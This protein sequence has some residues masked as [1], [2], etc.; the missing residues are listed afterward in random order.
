MEAIRITINEFLNCG[1]V[2]AEPGQ[3][4]EILRQ[5]D[6]SAD[7]IAEYDPN[8]L[9]IGFKIF[10]N[11]DE[12]EFVTAALDK[13]IFTLYFFPRF[14]LNFKILFKAF[15]T[16]NINTVHN[17]I[18]SFNQKRIDIDQNETTANI[19]NIWRI[20]ERYVRNK[21]IHQIGIS[22]IEENVFRVLYDWANVKPSIIQINLATCCVVPPSL[23]LFCKENEIQLLTHSDPNG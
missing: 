7:K 4:L 16:L 18:I 13:G 8:E 19:Q 11:S 20:L 10:L 23:Q 22:D 12:E 9:K 3:P 5:N 15:S 1:G 21:K 17:V 6:D 2:Q 14:Y